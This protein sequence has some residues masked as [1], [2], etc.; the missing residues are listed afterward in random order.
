MVGMSARKFSISLFT[1][2]VVLAAMAFF[3]PVADSVAN[4]LAAHWRTAA[5]IFIFASYLGAALSLLVGV[6]GFKR[7]LQS[8]YRFLS[9]GLIGLSAIFIQLVIW[10]VLDMWDSAWAAS[11]SGLFPFLLAGLLAY[12]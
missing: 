6:K 7:E 10:G 5:S 1:V 12:L 9:A 8:A 11:G 2:S 4:P 3:V